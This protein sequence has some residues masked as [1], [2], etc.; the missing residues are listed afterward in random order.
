MEQQLIY[1]NLVGQAIDDLVASL[2]TPDCVVLTDVN[3]ERF[4]LPILV[5]DSRTV[6][7][8]RRI[9]VK[10]GDSEKTLDELTKVWLELT[11]IGATRSTVVINVGGGVV[12]DLG[13][14]A[15]STFKRGLRCINVPTTVL[16]AV[17]ASIGGK[18]GINFNG[19]KNQIGTFSEPVATIISSIYFNT[20]P[21]QQILSGYAEMLKHGLLE[22]QATFDSL[23]AYKPVTPIFDAEGILA[24][25]ER[26]I[27]T[28]K[29]I[30]DAD[31]LETGLRKALNLGHTGGHAFEALAMKR[32]SPVPHGYA[33]AWGLVVALVLSHMELNFPTDTVHKLSDYV[34]NTFGVHELSCNDYPELLALMRQDKKNLAPGSITFTL[35]EAVG[36][37]KINCV[38]SEENIKAALDIYR[39]LTGQ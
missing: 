22:D 15:A 38:V 32:Q 26:S 30:C 39:D 36:K 25:I 37:P 20:L 11:E 23:L 33:V 12:T 5:N 1:T 13:G 8:A 9:V 4:V 21:Q 31:L 27:L 17:D 6:A 16:G 3:T 18:T 28:K 10:S 34:K 19:L 35:L 24:V 2:G 14:F 7:A 29:R